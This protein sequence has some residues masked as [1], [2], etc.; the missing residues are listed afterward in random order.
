[1]AWGSGVSAVKC[2][3]TEYRISTAFPAAGIE[4]FTHIVY[5][6][7]KASQ[8]GS[9][10][11]NGK[12]T[13]SAIQYGDPT[14]FKNGMPNM[15]LGKSNYGGDSYFK[16]DYEEFR[17]Y[18]GVLSDVEVSVHYVKGSEYVPSSRPVI[19]TQPQSQT[20]FADDAVTVSV[21]AIGAEPLSYQ[22]YKDGTAI[23][24]AIDS[25]YTINSVQM[26]DAGSYAVTVSNENGLAASKPA[27]LKVKEAVPPTIITQPKSQTVYE[28][29]SVTFSVF[30]GDGSVNAEDF[31]TPLSDDVDL[32]MVWIEP[33]TFIMGSPANELGR[34]DDEIQ[35]Q[36]TLTQGYWIGKYQ[37]TIEQ[38]RAIMGNDP[39]GQTIMDM[40]VGNVTWNDATNFCAILTEIE[41]A[42]GRLP[43][44]YKY[45][46]PTEAQWEYACRAG[47]TTAFNNGKDAT[48]DWGSCP[49]MDEVGWYYS[50]SWSVGLD[51]QP[52]GQKLP[53]AWGLY[54]M[55]GNVWEWCL[56]W[57]GSYPTTA[58]TDPTGAASGSSRV[59]RGGGWYDRP[60]ICRSACRRQSSVGQSDYYGFRVVL[61]ADEAAPGYAYQW[62]K[63]GVAID[64]ATSFI[65]T[66]G[67]AQIADSGSYTVT[68]TNKAGTVTSD[69]A[70]LTVEVRPATEGLE[71]EYNPDG[72][73]TV[74]GIGEAYGTTVLVIPETVEWEGTDY[75]VTSIGEF[76][77]GGNENLKAVVIP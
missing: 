14:L 17:I 13:A 19:V 77:F 8:R 46:L 54:D 60:F 51:A 71:Y 22:W 18:N 53:N 38:Y 26:T 9:I 37:V 74:I 4:G 35:H 66:I 69:E 48:S 11:V 3:G 15:W 52:V 30:A 45:T 12:L 7:D 32:D 75:T 65:Y 36:V 42:A 34:L 57:Y 58:V 1:M 59:C 25:S 31:S 27:V 47:T 24:G 62:F 61:A 72:T 49:N 63:D 2:Q 33:G 76:A 64:G 28:N 70:V 21:T 29:D 68:V 10:Y 43:E 16:G 20:V 6:Y 73:A 56:D 67:K 23:T 50:N 40:P 39:S 44:G 55:H 5:T 41:R